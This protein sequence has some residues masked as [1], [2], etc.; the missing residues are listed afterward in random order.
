[1]IAFSILGGEI[2]GLR[3]GGRIQTLVEDHSS[4]FENNILIK[5]NDK[6]KFKTGSIIG[7]TNEY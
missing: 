7:F 3:M 2:E 1:M 6:Y 4:L 5:F